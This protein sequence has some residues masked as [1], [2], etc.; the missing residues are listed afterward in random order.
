MMILAATRETLICKI[1]FL[2]YLS[3]IVA[4]FAQYAVAK[5]N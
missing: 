4:D 2:K 3:A 5:K 1:D